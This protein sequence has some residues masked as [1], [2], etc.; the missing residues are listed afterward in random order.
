MPGAQYK[1][2]A[3]GALREPPGTSYETIK[4]KDIV[5]I[6]QSLTNQTPESNR[7]DCQKILK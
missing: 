5:K 6:H 1:N 4:V 7:K 2:W 3:A